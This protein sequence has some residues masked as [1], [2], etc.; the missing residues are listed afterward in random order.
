MEDLLD[1]VSETLEALSHGA[2]AK[3]R[4]RQIK[5]LRGVRGT[6]MG[7]IA[8]IA[9]AAW[10]EC[11]PDL[12]DRETLTTLFATAWEDGLV[13][14]GLLAAALIDQ[15]AQGLDIALDWAQRVDDIATADALGWLVI[16][17]GALLSK[18]PIGAVVGELRD[19]RRAEVRRAGVMAAMAYLP[20]PIEGPSAAPLRARLGQSRTQFVDTA[21]S[22]AVAEL[23][24]A[25]LR[26][27]APAVRKALRR[28]IRT[29]TGADAQAV[30]DWA[31]TVRGGLPKL[32]RAEA[33]RARRKASK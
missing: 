18:Q 12:D 1:I 2:D 17:P 11:P 23:A 26:D 33:D 7:E 21:L 29:W 16:G 30:V 24:H 25:S 9:S 3:K 19:H 31:D 28:V 22:P 13:A 15:P 4:A 32:I 10:L 20:V 8:Q 14:I 6:P 5:T 27:E